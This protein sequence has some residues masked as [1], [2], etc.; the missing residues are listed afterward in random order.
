MTADSKPPTLKEYLEMQYYRHQA[1]CMNNGKRDTCDECNNQMRKTLISMQK[2]SRPPPFVSNCRRLSDLQ[3]NAAHYAAHYEARHISARH[4]EELQMLPR[5]AWKDPHLQTVYYY[6]WYQV[7]ISNVYNHPACPHPT[8]TNNQIKTTFWMCRVFKKY[9]EILASPTEVYAN[10]IGAGHLFFRKE[11]IRASKWHYEAALQ[12]YESHAKS[13]QLQKHSLTGHM[14]EFV[15]PSVAYNG[16][17]MA[18]FVLGR[19]FETIQKKCSQKRRSRRQEDCVDRFIHEHWQSAAASPI[20]DRH[21]LAV[22][23]LFHKVP[24]P[25]MPH[26]FN[27]MFGK[28][29]CA[30]FMY[31]LIYLKRC[32][33]CKD[34]GGLEYEV[35]L[36]RCKRC[37]SVYYCDKRCQKK[38]WKRSHQYQCIPRQRRKLQKLRWPI[39]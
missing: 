5:F 29:N 36:K 39:R 33:Y 35:K 28:S 30:R 11:K 3:R 1:V 16:C 20:A 32:N 31:N 15:Q 13:I 9:G 27:D 12:Y 37:K 7:I 23:V 19:R 34:L 21:Q 10:L 6:F 2:Q 4:E 26:P 17:I 24:P 8:I 38:D 18:D 14:R 22:K 25:R